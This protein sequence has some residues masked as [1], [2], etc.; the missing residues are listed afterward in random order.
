[1]GKPHAI[2][3]SGAFRSRMLLCF[4]ALA[5][6][7]FVLAACG[8][9]GLPRPKKAQDAFSFSESRAIGENNCLVVSGTVSGAVSSLASIT[10]ELA[11]IDTYGDCVGCPFTAHEHTT[12]SPAEAQLTTDGGSFF[13]T[14]CPSSSSRMY[15]WRLVGNNVRPGIPAMSTTPQIVTLR[16]VVPLQ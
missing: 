12:L 1:M 8:K 2:T 6:C 13:F 14:Y 15:R 10:L 9:E 16:D 7:F 3:I 5:L 4:V 11:G